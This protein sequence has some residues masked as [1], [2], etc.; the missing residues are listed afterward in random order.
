MH[1]LGCGGHQ[2]PPSR[3]RGL[4]AA[5]QPCWQPA[6]HRPAPPGTARTGGWWRAAGARWGW[7]PTTN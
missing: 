1:P 4:P 5:G 2:H 3:S 7:E 6:G